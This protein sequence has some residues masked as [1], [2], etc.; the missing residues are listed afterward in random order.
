MELN[1]KEIR[2]E[3][4]RLRLD[5][6]ILAVQCQHGQSSK[7]LEE[8]DKKMNEEQKESTIIVTPEKEESKRKG[9]RERLVTHLQLLE[10]AEKYR[11]MKEGVDRLPKVIDKEDLTP[12]ERN[13]VSIA[14]K[15]N[16]LSQQSARRMLT[17]EETKASTDLSKDCSKKYRAVIGKRIEAICDAAQK[18]VDA[19]LPKVQTDEGTI[20]M[21]KMK[22]DYYRYLSEWLNDSAY[23]GSSKDS[24]AI[25]EAA[26]MCYEKA[27]TLAEAK[28]H[29]TNPVRLGLA[30]NYSVFLNENMKNIKLAVEL[31][32]KAFDEAVAHIEEIPEDQY[33]DAS[34]ILQLLRDN[35]SSAWLDQDNS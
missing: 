29:P 10:V 12:A 14:Y 11:E 25:M 35:V 28:L 4:E 3:M 31:A 30:M 34:M 13:L 6:L 23:T 7:K 9:E 16:L 33:R 17:S 8:E 21:Q 18:T 26:K 27:M 32:K 19:L 24:P 1:A 2:L 5:N 22:A 20:F 15:N